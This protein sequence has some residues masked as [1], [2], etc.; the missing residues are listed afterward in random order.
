MIAQTG[1]DVYQRKAIA[2]RKRR[3]AADKRLAAEFAERRR[4]F[5]LKL[6]AIIAAREEAKGGNS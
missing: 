3:A 6:D 2:T 4:L 5:L 1:P